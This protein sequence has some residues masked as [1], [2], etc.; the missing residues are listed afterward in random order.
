MNTKQQTSLEK[1]NENSPSRLWEN[2]LSIIIP[3][4]NEEGGIGKVLEQLSA[5]LPEAEII[6]VNDASTDETLIRISEFPNVTCIDSPF[7]R[8][9]GASLKRGMRIAKGKYIAWFDADN[10]HRVSDLIQMVDLLI[11]SKLAAVI[12][13]RAN[14]A[15]SVVR[16]AGKFAIKL[17]SRSLGGPAIKDINCGLRV[18]HAEAI[19]RYLPM[20]PD[21]FSA[22]MTSTMLL[23]ERQYPVEFF[24]ISVAPRI[25]QSKV[26]LR[27]GFRA[28]FT[29]LRIVMLVAPMRIFL[30]GGLFAT[31]FG[32]VYGLIRMLEFGRSFPISA[33][34]LM[35]LGMFLCV[36][37]LIADQ[38][39]QLRFSL[40]EEK[41]TGGE[42]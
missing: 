9:Y 34:V 17:L 42:R 33:F 24:R 23:I 5:E 27:D 10:E 18:F 6:V 15:P 20:L 40:V 39:S 3:A 13:E 8:G 36:L 31:G 12:G 29:V 32:G 14:P 41:P 21:K 1:A 7:N 22:S 11:T 16:S 26:A 37:G 35:M 2:D 28:L 38:A 30:T 19:L 25:G 4:Y